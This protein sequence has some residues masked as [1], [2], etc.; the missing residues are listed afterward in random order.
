MPS[1]TGQT[2]LDQ[3]IS[4]SNYAKT[5]DTIRVSAN[6]A[7]TDSSHIWLDMS[8]L[9]G[10]VAYNDVLCSTPPSGVT[11][12]YSSGVA[13]YGFIAGFGG[14]V[15]NGSRQVQFRVQNTS[16]LNETTALSSITVDTMAPSVSA[17]AITSPNGGETWGGTGRTITWN[18]GLVTDTVG[19]ASIRLEYSTGANVWNLI[20]NTSNAG[21]Y[22]W[23]I[24][25]VASRNDYTIRLTAFDPVG[26]SA[27]DISNGVFTIDRT[28]PTVPSNTLIVPNGGIYR[29]GSLLSVLWNNGSITDSGGLTVKPI[30]LEY[31]ID[32]GSNWTQIGANLTNS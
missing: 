7:N 28:A 10:S 26:N 13:T 27:S 3:T 5:G 31:S 6:I 15:S 12:S 1:I 22:I 11:C 4:N 20:A 29:G 17:S 23:D 24:T 8:S 18:T 9:A 21:S 2:I 30:T 16:G 25:S 32:N 19:I 14:L